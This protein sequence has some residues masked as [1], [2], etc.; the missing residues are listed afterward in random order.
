MNAKHTPGPWFAGEIQSATGYMTRA[1]YGP[2]GREFL[3]EAIYTGNS[4]ETDANTY[5]IAAA[6]DLL[7]AL[8]A[9]RDYLSCIPESAAGGDDA[10][11]ELCKQ[12]D[13]VIADA[14]GE[15]Q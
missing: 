3:A 5:L 8:Q 7:A 12:A 15:S 11:I 2:G 4:D 14:L 6:P 9:S 10:A 1:V 13:A